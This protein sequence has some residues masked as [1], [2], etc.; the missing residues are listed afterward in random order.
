M[1]N[2]PIPRRGLL[3]CWF[4]TDRG[5]TYDAGQNQAIDRSGRGNHA[6]YQNGVTVGTAGD[7]SRDFGAAAFDADSNQFAE[8]GDPLV[9]GGKQAIAVIGR[10]DDS[11]SNRGLASNADGTNGAELLTLKDG[12]PIFEII[13]NGSKTNV[14]GNNSIENTFSSIVGFFDGSKIGIYQDGELGGTASVLNVTA[15]TL[16]SF[17]IGNRG[18][19]DNYFDGEI[20]AVGRYDL[21]VPNAPEPSEIARRWDR[22]RDIPATR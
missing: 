6:T 19:V 11:S 18:N 22:L 20:A 13:N 5:I 8:V 14:F 17:L 10:L 16:P 2:R 9:V 3:G 15:P 4:L 21:T 12:F 1:T 7:P